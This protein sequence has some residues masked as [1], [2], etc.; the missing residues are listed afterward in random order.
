MHSAMGRPHELTPETAKRIVDAIRLGNY[1]VVACQL[2]GITETTYYRWLERGEDKEQPDGSWTLGEEPFR[3][4]RE[5]VK[6]AEAEAE[7]MAVGT[8]VVAS[9]ANASDALRFLERRYPKRWRPSYTT[10]VTGA[11]GGPIAIELARTLEGMSDAD[12]AA[13]RRALADVAEGPPDG[14]TDPEG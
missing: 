6:R 8:L 5:S 13:A 12:L 10:E 1:A 14:G 11:D 7:A 2:A 9:R 4:F 3:E